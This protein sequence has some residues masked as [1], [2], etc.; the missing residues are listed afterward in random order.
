MAFDSD[1]RGSYFI[2]IFFYFVRTKIEIELYFM[3]KARQNAQ[4]FRQ[5]IDNGTGQGY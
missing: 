5:K 2:R 3:E 1:D 4:E